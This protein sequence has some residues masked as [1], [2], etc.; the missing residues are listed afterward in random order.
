MNR[1]KIQKAIQDNKI[2][3]RSME[4][5]SEEVDENEDRTVPVSFS[6]EEP[7]EQWWGTE[8]LS[9]DPGAVDLSRLADNRAPCL[10]NHWGDQVGVVQDA[11]VDDNRGYADLRF[12]KSQLASEIYQDVLDGIRSQV[13]VGYQI[14]EYKVENVDTDDE[15]FRVTKWRPHEISI[16]KFAADLSVGVGRGDLSASRYFLPEDSIMNG[17]KRKATGQVVGDPPET[18]ETDPEGE[19]EGQRGEPAGSDPNAN[20][21]PEG[22]ELAQGKLEADRTAK[23]IFDMGH[24]VGQVDLAI[25]AISD[26][27]SVVEFSA[28]LAEATGGQGGG[29]PAVLRG[30]AGDSAVIKEDDKRSFMLTNLFWRMQNPQARG[31]RGGL[32]MELAEDHGK[33]L[34]AEGHHVEGFA[35]PHELLSPKHLAERALSA[36]T[37][38]AGGYLVQTDVLA[39]S[40]I[41]LLLEDTVAMRRCT[42]LT[43]LKGDITIPGQDARAVATFVGESDDVA[44]QTPTLRSLTLTPK[45][46]GAF[47]IVSNQLLHQASI[48]VEDMLR[49]DLARAVGKVSDQMLLS[50]SGSSNQP[51]GIKNTTDVAALTYAKTGGTPVGTITY[52]TILEAEE[53]LAD[54]NALEGQLAWVMAPNVRKAA[55]QK[56]KLGTGSSI[57]IYHEGKIDEYD[58]DVTTQVADDEAYFANWDDLICAVWGSIT[59]LIDPYVKATS[60]QVRII[61]REMMD[62]AVRHPKSFVHVD[63]AA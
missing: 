5:R 43:D 31:K 40:F 35:I 20:G 49:R 17:K 53:K 41:D 46:V 37:D 23:D 52:D 19:L 55:R 48:S 32:E 33:R 62:V 54:A 44:E 34:S 56:P 15:T 38:A 2:F 12:S 51:T 27:L 60:N 10:L 4:V 6:S 42:M 26:G 45:N 61:A 13:S 8:I 3:L 22:D 21:D 58:A 14:L 47:I 39:D 29:S 7:Y 63:K 30:G 59:F 57:P 9:H 24:R 28:K 25:R 50:G 11:R 16:V 1:D 36:G 18:L